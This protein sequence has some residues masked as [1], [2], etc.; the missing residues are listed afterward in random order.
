M[1]IIAG[2]VI[3]ACVK[4]PSVATT[5]LSAVPLLFRATSTLFVRLTACFFVRH[6]C[7]S[8]SICFLFRLSTHPCGGE[9]SFLANPPVAGK[10][11][12]AGAL[13]FSFAFWLDVH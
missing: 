5:R 1:H 13:A 9:P 3:P 2:A 11:F 10:Y 8:W 4:E 7:S 12:V 6:N